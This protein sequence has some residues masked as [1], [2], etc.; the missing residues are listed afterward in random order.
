MG[1]IIV[2][3]IGGVLQ[4]LGITVVA[5]LL[6]NRILPAKTILVATLFM[7]LG[8]I[9]LNSI[10]YF[11]IIY[12]TAVLVFFLKR[13]GSTWIISF[14]APMLSFIVIVIADYLVSWMVGEG[15]GF[16]L[17]DYNNVYLNFV[18]LIPNFVCAYLIGALIYWI[19]YKR[20]FQGVL[21]R[22]GFVIVALMAMTMAITYLFIYLEGALGFPKGLTTIYLILF[23]TF[24]ITI[25]IVFLIMDRIRKERDKHQKQAT[26]LAQ[27]RDYTERLEKLYTNMNTFRHDYINILASLHG[28]IVQGDRALLDAYFEEAI[29]PLKQD[30]PK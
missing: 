24:F 7:S 4:L 26:E 18:F 30:T 2:F 21:N 11:T 3:F 1:S 10:Q 6:A 25:S 27:L 28:Y 17:H 29:K 9:F 12:T 5:N 19:L 13:R 8:I 15:L 20:N 23:V 14:V 16:Y 22:N